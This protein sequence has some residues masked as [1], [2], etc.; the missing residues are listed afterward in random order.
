[1]TKELAVDDAFRS[2]IDRS[3]LIHGVF[4][5]ETD[6]GCALVAGAALD[7]VLG[8]LLTVYLLKDKEIA[9]ALFN[10]PNAPLST[11][12]SRIWFCRGLGLI[13]KE[14]SAMTVSMLL[15]SRVSLLISCSMC[16]FMP[17]LYLRLVG[18]IRG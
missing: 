5:K 16:L 12:S 11:F 6:R 10:N 15:R 7:E 4:R 2:L 13:S 1:M 8:G 14:V 18:E 3:S 9:N 17:L